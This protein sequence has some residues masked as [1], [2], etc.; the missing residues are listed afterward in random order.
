MTMLLQL[1]RAGLVLLLTLV[2]ILPLG[3]QTRPPVR[4]IRVLVLYWGEKD[5]PA[6]AAFESGFQAA[7]R[8]AAPR[9]VEFYSEFLESSRFPGENQ[10]QLL[11]DYI[12]QKYADNTIDVVVPITN[13]PLEFLF[14]YRSDFLTHT[15]IVFGAASYPSAA[16]LKSGA[17]ATGIVFANSYRKTI[18]LALRLHPRTEHV[19]IVSGTL[20]HDKAYEAMAA[21][22]LRGY[23]AK[24]AITYLTDLPLDQLRTKIRSLPERSVILYVWQQAHEAQGRLLESQDVLRSIAPLARV[25]LYGMTSTNVGLG[26]VGGYVWTMEAYTTKLAELTVKV[27]S[28]VRASSIPVESAPDTLMFDWRQLQ[29]WRIRENSLPDDSVIRFREAGPWRQYKWRIM[30]GIA[31]IVFESLLIVALLLQRREARQNAAALAGAQRVLAESEERFRNMADTAPVMLFVT[32]ANSQT[33]FFNKTWLDFTGRAMEQELGQGW[34][35]GLHPDDREACLAEIGASFRARRDCRLEYR[36]RR[37]DGQYRSV[38]CSGIPR[39]QTEGVFTGYIGSMIDITDLRASQAE[40]LA[41]QKLESLGVM[42]GGIAHD[43]NNLLGSILANVELELADLTET[44]NAEK[45]LNTVKTIAIRASEIVRQLMVYAGEESA[46]FENVDVAALVREMLQLMMLAVTKSAVLTIDVPPNLPLVRGNAALL[47]QVVMNLITNGSDALR[48]KGGEISVTLGPVRAPKQSGE[49]PGGEFLRLEIRDSGCGMSDDVQAKIFD[50]F[51]ST[52]Q[53]GRGMGLAAVRGIIQSHGGMIR[54]QSAVGVGSCFEVLLPC[55]GQTEPESAGIVK[56]G[57]HAEDQNVTATVLIIDDED[58]L[59]LPIANMLRR[60]GFSILETSDG[61][62]GVD[63]F[64]AQAAEI[65]VVLLD[66]TLPGMPGKVVLER[67][68]EICPG[69]K[70]V[71]STAYGRDRA[72]RDVAEPQ[73]VYYLRKPYTIDA[74]IALLQKVSLE[75]PVIRQKR[76]VKF[77]H[78]SGSK[79]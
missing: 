15:P 46:I 59:R 64:K 27:A 3:G 55:V 50:P 32:D 36:L 24:A 68:R 21:N 79:P 52:K 17:G 4:P 38:I 43:F 28:G 74:L 72:F 51:F 23:E 60:K 62:T 37:A 6:N 16:Q 18:D 12:R 67:L 35:A 1:S 76:N 71:V 31:L 78:A 41:S 70:V 63:L 48:E 77:R 34:T 5:R 14:K 13:Q 49:G 8:V 73:S 30:G 53:A 26:I 42:A 47:R 75:E 57:P 54:V 19:F 2:S 65:D 25:P 44:S 7:M 66:L 20:A 29:R 61:A 10:S 58:M 9:P 11:H 45:G 40:V 22:Q 69:V 33:T 39:F 56:S